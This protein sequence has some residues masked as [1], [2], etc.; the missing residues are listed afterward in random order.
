MDETKENLSA[1]RNQLE[2]IKNKI[3]KIISSETEKRIFFD[4]KIKKYKTI[5]PLLRKESE[6]KESELNIINQK[7]TTRTNIAI[8][9]QQE[10]ENE[11][12]N[13]IEQTLIKRVFNGNKNLKT[14]E[15]DSDQL[16]FLQSEV[17]RLKSANLTLQKEYQEAETTPEQ[18]SESINKSENYKDSESRSLGAPENVL[19]YRVLIEEANKVMN[20]FY[21]GCEISQAKNFYK[22][23]LGVENEFKLDQEINETLVHDITHKLKSYEDI[24]QMK[25]LDLMVES[26]DLELR[27]QSIKSDSQIYENDLYV[28]TAKNK[29]N[30][31]EFVG[32]GDFFVSFSDVMSVLLCFFVVFFSISDQSQEAFDKF[33]ATWPFKNDNKVVK[34]PNNV[35]LSE[36]EL[37]LIGRVKELV[38]SGVIPEALTRNDTKNIEFIVLNSD[39]FVPGKIKISFNGS[40]IL[41]EKIK[42][43]LSK[44]GIRQIRV[45][46]H[47]DDD[48][49]SMHQKLI[50]KYSNNLSFSIGRASAVSQI[51]NKSFKFPEKMT[52]ITGFGAKQPIKSNPLNLDKNINSRIVIKVLQDKKINN[53]IN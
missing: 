9:K 13:Q 34:R 33:F 49:F 31:G 46:G 20:G 17:A 16:L 4:G 39:I 23:V 42:N 1:L 28:E 51:L 41:K 24:Y 6:K 52:I 29:S 5:I 47:T 32:G 53:N 43:I 26:T 2:G 27:K 21:E 18:S 50:N 48:D 35:S 15:K 36:T 25:L 11:K 30:S 3:Q 22:E 7:I 37:K 8:S 19:K 38:K 14:V 45:E 10:E 44:G 12:L 40:N